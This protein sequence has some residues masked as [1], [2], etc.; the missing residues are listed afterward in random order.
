MRAVNAQ[1]LA[2]A[3]H[4]V[5]PVAQ[6]AVVDIRLRRGVGEGHVLILCAE[7]RASRGGGRWA[8]MTPYYLFDLACKWRS[9]PHPLA[10]IEDHPGERHAQH[11]DRA[12]GDHHAALVAKKTLDR[13]LLGEPHAAMDLHAAVGGPERALVAKNLHHEGLPAAV[14][15]AVGS[16]GGM[17]KHQPQLVRIHVDLG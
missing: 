1:E 14:L 5:E 9:W 2:H 13:Q 12:L 3:L 4:L 11:L 8:D 16:P 15:A 17:I 7:A 10:Q 6:A